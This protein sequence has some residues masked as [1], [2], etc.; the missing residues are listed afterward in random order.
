MLIHYPINSDQEF[1]R[2]DGNFEEMNQSLAIAIGY[3][4][5]LPLEIRWDI[6]RVKDAMKEHLIADLSAHI[7]TIE[8]EWDEATWSFIPCPDGRFLYYFLNAILCDNSHIK[9]DDVVNKLVDY[10][11]NFYATLYLGEIDLLYDIDMA[12]DMVGLDTA[13]I[14]FQYS[15]NVDWLKKHW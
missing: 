10:C 9:L 8:C 2:L 11:T 1:K 4:L 6:A 12:L 13:K 3:Y 15:D 5:L 7:E 14:S